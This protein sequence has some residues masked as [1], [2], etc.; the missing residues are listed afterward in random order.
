MLTFAVE[1]E[2]YTPLPCS[3]LNVAGEQL[4]AQLKREPNK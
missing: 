3:D 4:F 1:T 2:D